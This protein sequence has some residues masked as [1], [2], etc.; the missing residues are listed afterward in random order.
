MI[1]QSCGMWRHVMNIGALK[2]AATG[3][4]MESNTAKV[5]RI[6]SAYLRQRRNII[7]ID[8]NRYCYTD[9]RKI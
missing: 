1:I 2:S 3:V 6:N 9:Q 4:I 8:V 7:S 5:I